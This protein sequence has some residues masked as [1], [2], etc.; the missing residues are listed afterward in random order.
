MPHLVNLVRYICTSAYGLLTWIYL[1]CRMKVYLPH[2]S[3][4][5][6]RTNTSILPVLDPLMSECLIYQ[7][8]PGKTVVSWIAMMSN[9]SV[10][11]GFVDRPA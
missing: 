2:F 6:P 1:L 9:R 3:C 8:K 7:L 10:D 4:P 5:Q 11:D